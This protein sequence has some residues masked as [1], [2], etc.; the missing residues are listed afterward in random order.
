MGALYLEWTRHPVTRSF[1]VALT[2]QRDQRL[3]SAMQG[4]STPNNEVVL[5]TRLTEAKTLEKVI[6][7]A[8][9]GHY[10]S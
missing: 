5:R 1:L 10:E 9:T 4:A 7:Y 6:A 2:E 8:S 3:A